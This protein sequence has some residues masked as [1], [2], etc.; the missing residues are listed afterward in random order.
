LGFISTSFRHGDCGVFIYSPPDTTATGRLAAANLRLVELIWNLRPNLCLRLHRLLNSLLGP[1]RLLALALSDSDTESISDIGVYL[2]Q[3]GVQVDVPR[4]SKLV[5]GTMREGWM[6]FTHLHYILEMAWRLCIAWMHDDDAY[7][8]QV[9]CRFSACSQPQ[10]SE[11]Q[12]T[13]ISIPSKAV[14]LIMLA[15]SPT[16]QR[17]RNQL[18]DTRLRTT[19]AGSIGRWSPIRSGTWSQDVDPILHTIFT[20]GV[21]RGQL[22]RLQP[23]A[24][25]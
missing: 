21:R 25:S 10:L 13:K 4:L 3:V 7:L 8:Q 17:S 14:S 5:S 24:S 15:T 20:V 19:T 11:D 22:H 6:T 23:R 1:H 16:F 9:D 18:I 12:E 2:K